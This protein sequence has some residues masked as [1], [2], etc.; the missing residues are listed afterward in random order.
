MEKPQ[1]ELSRLIKK[2]GSCV[3]LLMLSARVGRRG[4]LVLVCTT[5]ATRAAGDAARCVTRRAVS[6][7]HRT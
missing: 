1:D 4:G 7:M 5:G 2:R 3:A 6:V